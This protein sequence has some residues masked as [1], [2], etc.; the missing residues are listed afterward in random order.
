M[1]KCPTCNRDTDAVISR[2]V[3]KQI[4]VGCGECLWDNMLQQASGTAKYWRDRQK[5]DYRRDITQPNQ[6]EFA[7]AYPEKFREIHGDELFRK[8]A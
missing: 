6:K 7:K 8:L 2:I 1:N 4:M 3:G 5:E